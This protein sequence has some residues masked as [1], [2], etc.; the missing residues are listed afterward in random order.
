MKKAYNTPAVEIVLLECAA[1]I[2]VGSIGEVKGEYDGSL[3]LKGRQH[4]E[5]YDFMDEN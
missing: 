2:A 4:D 1:N 3:P 5:F